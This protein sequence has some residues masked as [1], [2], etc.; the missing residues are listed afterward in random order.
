[1]FAKGINLVSDGAYVNEGLEGVHFQHILKWGDKS[2]Y[3]NWFKI[4]GLQDSPLRMGVF[5]KKTEHVTHRVVNSKYKFEPQSD[6]IVKISRNN[7][8]N[9]K[10]PTYIQIYDK[11]LVNAE[12]LSDKELIKAYDKLNT[13]N[14]LEINNHND[15]VVPYSFRIDSDAYKKNVEILNEYNKSIPQHKRIS[16][17]SGDATRMLSQFEYFGLGGKQESGFETW[18]A[19]PDIAN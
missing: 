13:D 8:Y 6:G 10:A 4:S 11:R 16:Y 9:S 15:T 7:K 2:P 12:N 19:N 5:G 1:M 17:K 18:D 14:H 3:F